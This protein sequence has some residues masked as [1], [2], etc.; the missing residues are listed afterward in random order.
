M[1][2]SVEKIENVSYSDVVIAIMGPTG[3]GKSTVIAYA[4]RQNGKK[5]IGSGLK[6]Q[7]L[8]VQ[9][10]K[11]RIGDQN[12]VTRLQESDRPLH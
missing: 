12:I 5:L 10:Y 3:T 7:T 11:I 9:P 1:S 8:Q 4:S 2:V 6:S